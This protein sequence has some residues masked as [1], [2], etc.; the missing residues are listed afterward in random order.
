MV[1]LDAGVWGIGLPRGLPGIDW[2]IVTESLLAQSMSETSVIHSLFLAPGRKGESL[3]GR[4]CWMQAK[5][6]LPCRPLP[7][8]RSLGQERKGVGWRFGRFFF[9]PWWYCG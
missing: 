3:V 6:V 1:V 2:L 9:F 7:P 4:D 8:P 5:L